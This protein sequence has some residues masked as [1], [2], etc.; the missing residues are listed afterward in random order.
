MKSHERMD[1]KSLSAVRNGKSGTR[2]NV[3]Q[4]KM[5]IGGKEYWLHPVY[6]LYGANKQGEVIYTSK[7]TPTKGRD[8]INGY[9]MTDVRG[10]GDKKHKSVYVHRFIY[11][12]YNG[13]IPEG[14]VI[15]HINDDKKDNRVKNL[16]LCTQKQ[17]CKKSAAK[18][19]Y[20]NQTANFKNRKKVKAINLET[21]EVSYYKSQY[22]A[23]KH[24]GANIS[25][26]IMICKRAYGYKTSTSKK[27]GCKYT[28]EYA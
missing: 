22:S 21:N 13:L 4:M 20:S 26:V 8:N 12:C 14:M 11:E 10:S 18:R 25:S 23:G 7:Y 24:L 9:M 19:D 27:D 15:D 2:F 17:N 28:F 6:N 5:F 16:Q 3:G 1:V